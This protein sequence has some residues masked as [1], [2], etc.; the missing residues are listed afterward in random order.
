MSPAGDGV[1]SP[2]GDGGPAVSPL[3]SGD[4]RAIAGYRLAG[5]LGQ[6]GQ[7]VVFLGYG[8]GGEKAAVKLL[9]ASFGSNATARARFAREVETARRVA[10]YCTA[11]VLAA[12]IE[13]SRPYVVSE[14]IDGPSLLDFVSR[15]GPQRGAALTRLAIGTLAA[16][17]AVHRAGIVH[18]DFKP[19]NV[20]L[21]PE[22]PRV[23]DF[24]IARVLDATST[25]TSQV[26]GTPAF[27]A[28]EQL[29][30]QALTPATDMFAWGATMAYA[31]SGRAPF[32]ADSVAAVIAGVLHGEADLTGLDGALRPVIASCLAKD[33]AE[34]PGASDLLARLLDQTPGSGPPAAG[35]PEPGG[36]PERTLLD[37]ANRAVIDLAAAPTAAAV[38]PPPVTP[39]PMTSPQV[40]SPP[41]PSP[42]PAPVRPS[43]RRLLIGGGT[44]AVAGALGAGLPILLRGGGGRDGRARWTH[45]VQ[46]EGVGQITATSDALF[47]APD[48][49]SLQALDAATGKTRWT[50][51]GKVTR[52]VRSGSTLFAVDGDRLKSVDTSGGRT[53]WSVA[54][55]EASGAIQD[56]ALAV[57]GDAVVTA[58]MQYDTDN[59]SHTA[60]RAVGTGDGKQRWSKALPRLLQDSSIVEITVVASAKT[61]VVTAYETSGQKPSA[62][63]PRGSVHALAAD[64]G[65]VLW[66]IRLNIAGGFGAHA[67]VGDTVL[68]DW[69]D[70][71]GYFYAFDARTGRQRWR[72]SLTESGTASLAADSHAVYFTGAHSTEPGG[73]STGQAVYAL[74]LATGHQRWSAV[75]QM[76]GDTWGPVGGLVLVTNNDA[77]IW[78]LDTSTGKAVWNESDLSKPRALALNGGTAFVVADGDDRGA[79]QTIHA[80]RLT[81]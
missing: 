79:N 81:G 17:V 25:L 12:D 11:Q 47:F 40:T 30:G 49:G 13:G 53:H 2:A 20:L 10:S 76:Y 54:S 39:R 28:P 21:P 4:P 66:H 51:P 80:L 68:I 48:G 61:V 78:A 67:V 46:G 56:T 64:T 77:G 15:S 23:V 71:N 14:F 44:L 52:L 29:A 9:H 36:T 69:P 42:P 27:M 32:G 7:G 35:P 19:A 58:T 62:S 70:L 60:V 33:P 43:R 6:G 16:L 50:Q 75:A 55:S 73:T 37:A 65:E 31:A 18:R 63:A 74:D 3:H 57:A 38:S 26:I 22:G 59:G 24:G 34:R 41:P 45:T 72:A 5:R 8:P 1:P